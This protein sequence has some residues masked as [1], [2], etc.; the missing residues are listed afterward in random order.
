MFHPGILHL[1]SWSEAINNSQSIMPQFPLVYVKHHGIVQEQIGK[2]K[3]SV[4]RCVWSCLSKESLGSMDPVEG[5][6]PQQS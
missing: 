6:C 2:G 1:W 5:V 4:W 3:G